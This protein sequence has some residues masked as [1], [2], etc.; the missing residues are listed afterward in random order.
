MNAITFETKIYEN[1]W[2]YVLKT[3][4]LDNMISRCDYSFTHKW[5][6]I[7]N[8]KDI[9]EVKKYADKKVAK[10]IIDK[11]FV[12]A[13]YAD[14]A[15]AFFNI[16]KESFKG[17]YYYSIAELVAL[18]LCKTPY[19]LH[20]SSDSFLEKDGAPWIDEAIDLFNSHKEIVV[21]NPIWNFRYHEAESESEKSIGNFFA[22][23]GG[24]SD[25][26]YLIKTA[27]FKQPNV[28]NELHP[29]SD[30]YP[31]YG[32]ELFEKRVDSYLRNHELIRLN[33]KKV[34]YIHSNFPKK[35]LKRKFYNLICDLG[36][37][38]AILQLI[39]KSKEDT[40]NRKRLKKQKLQNIG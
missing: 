38:G 2:Q 12:V 31:K 40:S 23:N 8:V 27:V 6:M 14:E 26:C 16:Q 17:G 33:S 25:Q 39:E 21:A 20:F 13:D 19:L 28:F 36:L 32:G 4:Y 35:S 10:G 11:Y 24:F 9:E 15:L 29:L 22:S 37:Q 18:Y 7:N 3:N 30:R 5:L 1:D 34:S